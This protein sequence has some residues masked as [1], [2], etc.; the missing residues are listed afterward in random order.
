[1]HSPTSTLN[2]LRYNLLNPENII[3]SC[4]ATPG[5]PCN[6]PAECEVDQN[7]GS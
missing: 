2:L 5:V 3:H 6:H 1:M 7:D 4:I